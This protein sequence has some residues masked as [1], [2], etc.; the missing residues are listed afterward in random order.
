[1][2]AVHAGRKGLKA[3]CLSKVEP[4]RSHTVAAKGGINAALGN[5]DADDWR[6]HMFDTL[7]G[8]D[9]LGDA[10]AIEF[11]CRQAPA[12][13]RELEQMGVPFSRGEDGKLYQRIY[14]GQ[15]SDFGK[16]P[17]PHRACAVADR[18]G[19]A[20]LHT[21][22]QQALKHNVRFFTDHFA[23]DLIMHEGQCYGAVSWD[24]DSGE[25]HIF[26][27][28]QTILATGGYGQA[29]AT[30]TSS[31]ICTGDGNAMVLRAGLPLQDM[32]FIQ[33]HPT[34]LHGSGFLITEAARGEGAYLTNGEGERFMER[35]AP[36]Y[37]DL[38]ARD[39][40]ARA[41]ATEILQGRGAGPKKDHLLL[42]VEHLGKETVLHKL[43]TVYENART[44]AKI[45]PLREPIP[46]APSVHYTMGGIPTNRFA[47]ALDSRGGSV[48]GLM[49]VGETACVSVH[50][51]NR[52]GCNSL[53]DIVVFGK[54]AVEQAA[55]TLKPGQSH[56][57]ISGVG[58][59]SQARV[60]GYLAQAG[61]ISLA[62]LQSMLKQAMAQY[63]GV[64]RTEALL[65]QGKQQVE[66]VLVAL[67]DVDIRDRSRIWN[68][69][70]LE[71]LELENLARQAHATVECALRRQES[72]GSHFREDFPERDDKRGR[73]HS[74]IRYEGDMAHYATL[75][76]RTQTED[77][78]LQR[79]AVEKRG[80]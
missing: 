40:I 37:K 78:E 28:H 48:P 74:L 16:G 1:M 68:T 43:P 30:N 54:A 55:F 75:P 60:Q 67:K 9:W 18:T 32:E 4:T 11:M 49:A 31:S 52:L 72:R 66:Q 45:D 80:Y 36:T 42:H 38:A 34:G 57:S 17:P 58:V 23:L 26:R 70:L 39:V 27:A 13:I 62:S 51:A 77:K 71:I 25:I 50:G 20:I 2:A 56:K 24:I 14:G 46:V 10:D 73:V 41:M 3:A 29:Y 69:T 19:H 5:Q 61:G 59:A 8:G 6:W 76:V 21:L 15:S 44:F 7:R 47:E 33:F 79:F 64:F 35:Y 12:T 22:Y 65:Q 53:L 63:A